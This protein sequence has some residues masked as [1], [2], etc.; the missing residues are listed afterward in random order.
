VG[1]KATQLIAL[2]QQARTPFN[3]QL[4][5]LTGVLADASVP[6]MDIRLLCHEALAAGLAVRRSECAGAMR[7]RAPDMRPR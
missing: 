1:E 3:E 5:R 6:D 4:R 2:R 7:F